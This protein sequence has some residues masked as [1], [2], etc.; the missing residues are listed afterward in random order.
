[1]TGVHHDERLGALVVT[2]F[3]LARQVLHG[4]GWV[5]DLEVNLRL[6]AGAGGA[7]DLPPLM[8]TMLDLF[9]DGPA[10]DRF[11]E[12]VAPSFSAKR[13]E[14]LRPWIAEIAAAG[15]AGVAEISTV[16]GVADLVGLLA[17]PVP[18]AVI[19]GLLDVGQEGAELISATAPR[20]TAVLETDPAEEQ[21]LDAGHAAIECAMFLLP[22]LAERR[23]EPGTDFVSELLRA[24]AGELSLD[25][26]LA[27][28]LLLLIAGQET[29]AS[30]IG[31][32]VLDL[33]HHPGELA[34]LR[35]EPGRAG[36]VVRE[37]LRL[38]PPLRTTG[39]LAVTEQR[40]GEL[41][42]PAGQ[43]VLVHLAEA[44][45]DPARF[46]E[47]GRFAPGRDGP[48][49]LAFGGGGHFCLGA[50]LAR[51]ETEEVLREV[52]GQLPGL[53]LAEPGPPRRPSQNFH[54]L[55]RLLIRT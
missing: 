42:V 39:R 45:R 36:A 32:G 33:L 21:L 3:P 37:V 20:L 9:T 48:G 23:D 11:R 2:S 19:A 49:H 17:H 24:G 51:V 1:M 47:P 14:A 46:T 53:A 5:S 28:V 25:E 38:D 13:I 12:L 8:R 27:I 34:A 31:N 16:D 22:L 52:A 40:L 15:V 43:K 41:V 26:A 50:A 55:R 44:N 4:Q 35:A 54:A 29:T 7:E 6:L 18:V 30:L 10:H